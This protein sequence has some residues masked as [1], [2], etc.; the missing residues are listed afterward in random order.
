MAPVAFVPCPTWFV[1]RSHLP[2]VEVRAGDAV[3]SQGGPSGGVWVL[4]S[5]A[6]QVL[7]GDVAVNTITKPGAIVGEMSV[8]LGTDH[9]ATVVATDAEHPALR[10]GRSRPSC[11]VIPRSRGSS[12]WAWPSG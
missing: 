5:G 11:S 1:C 2:L 7:K 3:V 9:G 8:L 12:L 10:R 6:L 4:L